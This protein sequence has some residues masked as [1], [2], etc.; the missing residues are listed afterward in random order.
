MTRPL[1]RPN[2]YNLAKQI[3]A[4]IEDARYP[5]GHHLIE[6]RLADTLGVSRTPTRAA[7]ALLADQG[8]VEAR[9]NSGFYLAKSH[10]EIQRTTIEVPS[11]A[12]QDL[13]ARLVKDRLE[14]TIPSSFTQT[15]IADRCKVNRVV[16]LRTLARLAEDGLLARNR[17]Q[18]WTFL[19]TLD[20]VVALKSS[21]DFRLT[22]EPASFLLQSF[23]ADAATLQ[24]SRERHLYLVRH[25]AISS[26]DG[27]LLFNTD[28]EFHEMFAEFSRNTFYLQA[29]QQ[30]NRLRR[31]LEFSGYKNRRRVQDWCR[32]HIAIIDA[33][34]E[35]DLERAAREMRNHL[36]N[37]YASV[38]SLSR[39]RRQRSG[40]ERSNVAAGGE[41]K[42]IL[43]D[44]E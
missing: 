25:R 22:L 37:A 23:R 24:R 29:M 12:D 42:A 4:L 32:E 44:T 21:Y 33:V 9:P 8:I 11:T 3:L 38:P 16:L 7:L 31:L 2:S 5:E 39:K 18:G 15:Q 20:S 13:Y 36:S 6:Q 43:A 40:V 1:H 27:A 30:Q 10:T 17:G 19:P 34:E 41:P 35:G 14:G 28:A 26:V